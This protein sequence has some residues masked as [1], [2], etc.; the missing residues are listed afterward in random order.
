MKYREG[1]EPSLKNLSCNIQGGMKVGIVGRTGA[2]KSTILQV[3][4]RL[5]DCYEGKITID[6]QNINDVGLH[7]LRQNIAFIPQTPFLIQG[8]IRENIDPFNDF[9]DELIIETLEEVQ[10]WQHIQNKCQNG[11]STIL[12]ES[13]NLFS[14]GQK[15]LLCLARAII[16]KSKILVLDE[17]TANVDLQTDNFI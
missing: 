17:A 3:L 4:F 9:G 14:M 2:G 10:L 7:K 16:R 8:T 15:Q 1:M 12:T 11:L 6:G 13:N 5:T